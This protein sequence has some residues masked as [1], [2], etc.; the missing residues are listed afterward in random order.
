[1]TS[2]LLRIS[3]ISSPSRSTLIR[4]KGDRERVT[5]RESDGK[6]VVAEMNILF[7]SWNNY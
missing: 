4:C 5:G 1:M 7:M 2:A 3:S 6:D